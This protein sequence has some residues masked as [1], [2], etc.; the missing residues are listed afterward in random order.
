MAEV[1][2]GAGDPVASDTT[3]DINEY[4]R[5]IEPAEVVQRWQSTVNAIE[6]MNMTLISQ[7]RG[8]HDFR[9]SEAVVRLMRGYIEDL[10][11]YQT[12]MSRLYQDLNKLYCNK[13][14]SWCYNKFSRFVT[15]G[16]SVITII[17]FLSDFVKSSYESSRGEI[18]YLPN[19]T[20]PELFWRDQ[21][22]AT[23]TL[24]EVCLLVSSSICTLVKEHVGLRHTK[25]EQKKALLYNI[26]ADDESQSVISYLESQCDFWE[27]IVTGVLRPLRVRAKRGDTIV[28]INDIKGKDPLFLKKVDS[29][30]TK[31]CLGLCTITD[32]GAEKAQL[33]HWKE[34]FGQSRNRIDWTMSNIFHDDHDHRLQIGFLQKEVDV[35]SGVFKEVEKYSILR[36]RGLE[37][38]D[39]VKRFVIFIIAILSMVF[40]VY[41]TF[42]D[43]ILEAYVGLKVTA[44]VLFIC[45][46]AL[47]C[48][49]DFIKKNQEVLR[50]RNQ[51]VQYLKGRY[52]ILTSARNMVDYFEL[53]SSPRLRRRAK[54]D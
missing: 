17:V 38:L 36:N 25:N 32:A 45:A 27:N 42:K 47:S 23:F 10:K 14:G 31:R 33:A 43:Y 34:V 2:I 4:Q 40:M 18:A 28:D 53:K 54:E 20:T 1:V 44:F 35:L 7:R 12:I 26:L 16:S 22:S 29:S 3:V 24:L 46:F 11:R 13:S 30:S 50:K 15:I 8:T 6:T 5:Q 9:P 51:D 37:R 41:D 49:S 19:S 21:N 48:F 52:I 39:H